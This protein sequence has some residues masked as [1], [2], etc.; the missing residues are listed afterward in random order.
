MAA[1]DII[2]YSDSGFTGTGATL[3]TGSS[4]TWVSGDIFV[5]IALV[6]TAGDTLGPPSTIGNNLTFSSFIERQNVA[7]SC[8]AVAWVATATGSGNGQISCSNTSSVHHWGIAVWQ[9]RIHT[10]D[11]GTIALGHHTSA[12]GGGSSSNETIG[13]AK[14]SGADSFI[15]WAVADFLPSFP[16]SIVP[17]P[18]HSRQSHQDGT[19]YAYIIADLDPQSTAGT[20]Q[21]GESGAGST[22][23]PFTTIAIEITGPNPQFSP[24]PPIPPGIIFDQQGIGQLIFELTPPPLTNISIGVIV[25]SR[26][27]VTQPGIAESN[28]ESWVNS[29]N[30]WSTVIGYEGGAGL[31]L[32]RTTSDS[33]SGV[34]SAVQTS[35]T[36]GINVPK[37]IPPEFILAT[38]GIDLWLE[39]PIPPVHQGVFSQNI[40]DSLSGIDTITR[41][42]SEARTGND[43]LAGT[44]NATQNIIE[45]RTASDILSGIDSATQNVIEARTTSDTLSGIDSATQFVSTVPRAPVAIPVERILAD[46]GIDPWLEKPI[47]PVH[48]GIFTQNVTDS[49]SGRDSITNI[50]EV[51]NPPTEYL[52]AT[53]II[54]FVSL[55]VNTFV[56]SFNLT[57][58]NVGDIVLLFV[59]FNHSDCY[60]TGIS[61]SKVTWDGSA[62]ISHSDTNTSTVLEIWRG[63]VTSTGSDTVTISYYPGT[64]G[65]VIE[66]I[67]AYQFHQ[68]GSPEIWTTVTTGSHVDNAGNTNINYPTLSSNKVNDNQTYVGYASSPGIILQSHTPGFYNELISGF[69]SVYNLAL[70]AN[71]SYSPTATQIGSTVA[72]EIAAIFDSPPNDIATQNV[73]LSRTTSDVLSGVDSGKGGVQ[74]AQSMPRPIPP[75]FITAQYGLSLYEQQP[76]SIPVSTAA[77]LS[78][79]ASDSLSGTDAA[80]QNVALARTTSDSLSGVDS[81]TQFLSTVPKAPVPI[82]V[83][84]ILAEYGLDLWLEKPVP[85][86]HQGGGVLNSYD[87][88]SGIDTATRTEN[89][90]HTAT[91]YLGGLDPGVVAN[92]TAHTSIYGGGAVSAAMSWSHTVPVGST[93]L[94][95]VIGGNWLYNAVEDN[96]VTWNGTPMTL[97]TSIG[98]TNVSEGGNY[99]AGSFIYA[100]TNPQAG[101]YTVNAAASGQT[102]VGL[103]GG[104]V[105]FY[106]TNTSTGAVD[107]GSSGSASTSLTTNANVYESS[108]VVGVIG[109]TCGAGGNSSATNGTAIYQNLGLYAQGVAASYIGGTSDGH[110]ATLTYGGTAAGGYGAQSI[111]EVLAANAEWRQLSLPRTGSDNLSGTDS[112]TTYETHLTIPIPQIPPE[113]ITAQYGLELYEETRP[114]QTVVPIGAIIASQVQV[115]NPGAPE[116]NTESWTNSQR[117]WTLIQ[118]YDGTA[119]LFL[120]RT[121]SESLSGIDV[122]TGAVRAAQSM[123]VPI[124][125][126]F[127]TA[128]YGLDIYLEQ[129][130]P[131]TISGNVLTRTASDVL[132]GIDSAT[133]NVVLTR[134]TSDILSGIDSATQFVA[135]VPRAPVPIPVEFILPRYGLDIWL[136]RPL[137]PIHQ[138]SFA[139]TLYDVLSGID[140]ATQNVAL[141]RTTSDSLLGTDTVTRAESEA[142]TGSDILAGTDA[143]TQNV[144][145]SR[146]ANDNL[147]GT[148]SA[149]K[150]ITHLPG[151]VPIPPEF[152]LASY[153]MDL[154][155]EQPRPFVSQNVVAQRSGVEA[156]NGIDAAF[157]AI[158]TVPR[159]P[160]TIPPE[161]IL[162]NYGIDIW[163]RKPIPPVH[164]AGG[165]VTVYDSLLGI[166]SVT[167]NVVLTR[168]TSDVLSGIDTSAIAAVDVIHV[169]K[170]IPPEFILPKFGILVYE[171]Q[172]YVSIFRTAVAATAS[173][174]L[175][176]VDSATQ[177]VVL[178]RTTNDALNGTDTA[179]RFISTVP[180]APVAIPPEVI[181]GRYG[182]DPWLERPIPPISQNISAQRNCTDSLSGIDAATRNSLVL[183]RTGSD[184]L[185]GTDSGTRTDIYS[186]NGSD[187]S[188]TADTATRAG[189]YSRTSSDILSGIDT[190]VR[191][192]IL[193]RTITDILSGIDVGT[194]I[195]TYSRTATDILS[196]VDS[197]VG[198]TTFLGFDDLSGIDS[199]VRNIRL[200]R[201]ITDAANLVDGIAQVA[202][203][204]LLEV[205]ISLAVTGF[206]QVSVYSIFPTTN[207]VEPASVAENVVEP[208][209][210]SFNIDESTIG[211][212]IIQAAATPFVIIES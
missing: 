175:S 7:S 185:N 102:A 125:P 15:A 110:T 39:K 70:V 81:L 69:G 72:H 65:G 206:E 100:L 184:S 48:Q 58:N 151:P 8:Q 20:I 87:S 108:V 145:L 29:V 43:S 212:I 37:P 5:A 169:P 120:P 49:L 25:D 168:T 187:S 129:R 180:L 133:Q 166:D 111:A 109:L 140:S 13:L 40:T 95:V 146:T 160:V 56:S 179:T 163:L 89:L 17:T 161:F 94:V 208:A 18:T 19:D 105:S 164:Q 82:P 98:G 157:Y 34:D 177:N 4:F 73:V 128:Q 186:R 159:A 199:A 62:L 64:S 176:G 35:T 162:A 117:A 9:L 204:Q 116:T 210:T 16:G 142:R 23:G 152:I 181:L 200:G 112:A 74:P 153:G 190:S 198:S 79:T 211:D 22:T 86:I 182:L 207:I 90:S 27:E 66:D 31:F 205:P 141:A 83:E 96:G 33:L 124:P 60:G 158:N 178:A 104:S 46:Y 127:I 59:D 55:V 10:G 156:L 114:P 101:T 193:S 53:N 167:Q 26:V 14:T 138:G 107:R 103:A 38:Y 68:G 194:R 12:V 92:S 144:V 67:Y 42:E 76:H 209:A 71:T 11:S 32:P 130:H 139:Y 47:P 3:T 106:G 165:A 150:Y 6:E 57:T 172:K 135:T 21:Y 51:V 123:P 134:T 61:S 189:T 137:P 122:A 2:L 143:A 30:T 113:I 28:L 173:D 45:A 99:Y 36:H 197:A 63:I 203:F 84:V 154:W 78:R 191:G 202:L 183:G 131:S 170:P 88:L 147:N 91:D 54:S 201:N 50:A 121:G 75:E 149:T 41:Q 93:L 155:L 126:E 52:H 192:L 196:G 136:E 171:Q 80:T 85:P 24:P 148:D 119:G 132:S 174:I 118:T 44:D 195:G 97:I 115:L 188:V 77:I 1:P